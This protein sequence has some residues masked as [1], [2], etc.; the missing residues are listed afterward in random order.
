MDVLV[1][2]ICIFSDLKKGYEKGFDRHQNIAYL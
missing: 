1:L 2:L